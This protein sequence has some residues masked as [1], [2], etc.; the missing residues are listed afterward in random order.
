MQGSW[1]RDAHEELFESIDDNYSEDTNDSDFDSNNDSSDHESIPLQQNNSFTREESFDRLREMLQKD[2][3]NDTIDANITVSK[4]EILLAVLKFGLIYDLSQ[5]AIADL[6]KM[7][8]CIFG[9]TILPETRYLVDQIFSSKSNLEYH[10]VCP[11]YK[12][13]VKKFNRKNRRVKCSLCNTVIMLKSPTYHDFFVIVKI[14]SDVVNLIENNE[15]HYSYIVNNRI[16]NRDQFDDF[17]DG[18][19]YKRFIQK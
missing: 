1:I 3:N 6:F 7:L 13:Y 19:W 17:T 10:A 8:N 14:E 9:F 18:M 2:D 12:T 5:S 16:E 15:E 4:S 11:N